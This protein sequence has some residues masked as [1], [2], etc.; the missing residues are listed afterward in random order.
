MLSSAQLSPSPLGV[1]LCTKNARFSLL[2]HALGLLTWTGNPCGTSC[3]AAVTEWVTLTN[4]EF[5]CLQVSL[6]HGSKASCLLL[7]CSLEEIL[8]LLHHVLLFVLVLHFFRPL[9]QKN[10]IEWQSLKPNVSNR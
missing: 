2:L 9:V 1:S 4:C 6:V 8:V 7:S 5:Q 10:A 3:P